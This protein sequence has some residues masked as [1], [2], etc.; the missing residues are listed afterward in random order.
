VPG[1]LVAV[2]LAI[3]LLAIAVGPRAARA[4]AYIFA[5]EASPGIVAHPVGYT[6]SGGSLV[7]T[8]CIDPDYAI[9]AES[10][11]AVRNIVTTFNALV[12]TTGNLLFGA[13][14]N[15]PSGEIDA[16]STLLHELGH[17]LGL[18]HPNLATESGLGEPDRNYT[19]SANGADDVWNLGIG[20]DGTRGSS[21]DARGDDVNLHWFWTAT[22]DPFTIAPTVD[23]STYSRNLADL[24]AGHAFAANGDR[25]VA[26]LL[27]APSTEAVMQQ[28]AY[29]DE[30]QRAL[31][32]DDV[33]TLRYATTGL[34][35]TAGTADDY[36]FTLSYVGL[37]DA[38]H[39]VIAYDNVA[40]FA[41]CG[42]SGA[43]VNGT[44][45]R[46]TSGSISMSTA[47][48][49]FFNDE[50]LATVTPTPAAT[51]TPTA[52]ATATATPTPTPTATVT[53][54]V[55]AT[56]TAT[57]T[58]TATPTVTPTATIT[59]TVTPTI[60]STPTATATATPTVTSTAPTAT[61]TGPTPTVTP[62]VTAT[63]TPTATATPTATPSPTPTATATASPTATP[64]PTAS[65][66]S[67]AT[68]P[69]ACTAAPP[70]SGPTPTPAGDDA[71]ACQ[72]ALAK[73]AS[74]LFDARIRTIQKCE[75][76]KVAGKLAPSVECAAEPATA[77][78]L[79]KATSKLA[80]KVA[81]A[82]GGDDRI[83]D[84]GAG[85]ET[86][87]ALG[88]AADCP[89]IAGGCGGALADCGDVADCVACI[90]AEATA[91]VVGG[92]YAGLAPS[93]PA[94]ERALNKCQRTIGKE[95]VRLL[96]TRDKSVQKC[97]DDRL[98]GRHGDACPDDAAGKASRKAAA[99]I[100]K[101][102]ARYVA[103]LCRAC[104]GGDGACDEPLV[105]PNGTLFPGSGAADDLAPGAIGFAADCAAAAG[106]FGGVACAGPVASLAD[107]VACLAC[108]GDTAVTCVDRARVPGFG[109]YPCAC[110]V[111]D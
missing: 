63:P 57:V 21:D 58:P 2:V 103:K 78:R 38:C 102:E 39:I 73:E 106:G 18:A 64:I 7:V 54:T 104:G 86:P 89:G 49:W 15:I 101:A 1:R 41:S 24:P 88:F 11:I 30:D 27:G 4:G 90:A 14:N 69:A 33:A 26:T 66:T 36:T 93:D 51:P 37:T 16:E 32:H 68:P 43:Y 19:K 98:R 5:T 34:D 76:R 74:R 20:A 35:E 13:S 67:S 75:D 95:L 109:A 97:W 107:A 100:A 62:T 70:P 83:C 42:V 91:R 28:G 29:S 22:N 8:V 60:T 3:V 92:T 9:A 96:R 50:L 84:G 56:P 77:A 31:T 105:G 110:G 79:A 59:A 25:S 6:G 99:K 52:T 44:H 17:C 55:T 87:A 10:E 108:L 111:S 23:A 48:S 46:I 81:K 71:L 85:E 65:P 45:V 80:A 53:P 94:A 82:C 40:S 47:Y 12:P 61:A 72:R